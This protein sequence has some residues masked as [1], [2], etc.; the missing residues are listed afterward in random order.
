[1]RH[2]LRLWLLDH[3][4]DPEIEAVNEQLND[5]HEAALKQLEK[6]RQY[7][8]L[9]ERLEDEEWIGVYLDLTE[10]QFWIDPPKGVSYAIP[11]FIVGAY[12]RKDIDQEIARI[13]KFFENS[14][15]TP[16]CNWWHWAIDNFAP[17]QESEQ[18][19]IMDELAREFQRWR[20]LEE[21]LKV[22]NQ[23]NIAFP[24]PLPKYQEMLEAL[25][26]WDLA[27]AYQEGP[28]VDDCYEKALSLLNDDNERRSKL[29]VAAAQ[30]YEYAAWLCIEDKAY[31]SSIS[32]LNR[33]IEPT[34]DDASCYSY[35]GS[36][37][38]ELKNYEQALQDCNYAISLDPH[39]ATIYVNRGQV[40]SDIKDHEKALNDYTRAI[41]LDSDN[42]KAFYYRSVQH[43]Y[44][45]AY[46]HVV[47]D[48]THA[49]TIDSNLTFN[50]FIR[51]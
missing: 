30:Y 29:K 1:V 21:L 3:R 17:I 49:I 8:S 48:T 50:Y 12:Y 44:N 23:G 51:G 24:T 25:L 10:Q 15:T 13:G 38:R 27:D 14:I 46:K 6:D 4:R 45:K 36:A 19:P 33:A 16:Y 42:A 32:C 28:T 7:A 26:W 43:L 34:P 9:E 40:Y 20:G 39:N 11:F 2:F 41:E 22:A 31:D 18:L 35:R 47:E 37:Y 5:V